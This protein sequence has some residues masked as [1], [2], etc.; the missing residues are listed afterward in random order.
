MEKAKEAKKAV[1]TLTKGEILEF[2]NA[3]KDSKVGQLSN[4]STRDYFYLKVKMTENVKAISEQLEGAR[5][6]FLEENGFKEGDQIPKEKIYDVQSKFNDLERKILE[7][8]VEIETH[9]LPADE[10][11]DKLLNIDNNES[12]S[13]ENKATIMKYLLKE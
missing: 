11:F 1:Q 10:L 4:T 8:K 12:I 2:N 9:I 13:T 6:V 3:W 5:K 7:E